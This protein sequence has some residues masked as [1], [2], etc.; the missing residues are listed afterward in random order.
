MSSEC[1]RCVRIKRNYLEIDTR[2]VGQFLVSKLLNK[3]LIT[4]K[5][6]TDRGSDSLT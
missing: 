5:F 2:F 3:A 4:G 6:H 1:H